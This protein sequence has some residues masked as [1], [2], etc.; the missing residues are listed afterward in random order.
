MNLIFN[1]IKKT[2]KAMSVVLS[3]SLNFSSVDLS[4]FEEKKF[5][6]PL[7]K[8]E[9][10]LFLIES[11]ITAA[12]MQLKRIDNFY[13]YDELEEGATLEEL[14]EHPVFLTLDDAVKLV[15]DLAK[16]TFYKEEVFTIHKVCQQHLHQKIGDRIPKKKLNEYIKNKEA[17]WKEN[18]EIESYRITKERFRGKTYHV[19]IDYTHFN[20]SKS[21]INPIHKKREIKDLS[22]EHVIDKFEDKIASYR[23]DKKKEWSALIDQIFNQKV[24]IV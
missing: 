12:H 18:K 4:S 19:Y 17:E 16:N 3:P 1:E 13:L 9:H 5:S 21:C 20:D 22:F 8:D 11:F 24:S 6:D 10:V 15:R 14:N 23:L 2:E 7:L